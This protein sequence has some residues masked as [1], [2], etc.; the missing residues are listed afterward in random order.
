MRTSDPEAYDQIKVIGT[1]ASPAS[2]TQFND[3]FRALYITHTSAATATFVIT[4]IT[5]GV[6]VTKTITA[7]VPASGSFIL[8]I[9]GESVT[10]SFAGDCYALI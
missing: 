3:A 9:S 8:P 2:S 4:Q 1:I 10:A 6:A 5:N 7:R